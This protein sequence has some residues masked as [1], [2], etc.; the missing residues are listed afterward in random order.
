MVVW[1][2]QLGGELVEETASK[3]I[4]ESPSKRTCCHLS[5]F[6]ITRPKGALL[7]RLEGGRVG[8]KSGPDTAQRAAKIPGYHNNSNLG[9]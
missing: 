7:L 2:V 8:D 1:M 5:L 6:A 4:L 9:V 3:Q